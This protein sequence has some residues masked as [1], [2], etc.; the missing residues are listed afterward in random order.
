MFECAMA[1]AVGLIG[2]RLR[3]QIIQ[4]LVE[5]PQSQASLQQQLM[6]Q[7]DEQLF[8]EVLRGLQGENIIFLKKDTQQYSLSEFGRNMLPVLGLLSKWSEEG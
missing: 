1:S 2:S 5:G 7:A 8:A 6:P 4:Q 3:L